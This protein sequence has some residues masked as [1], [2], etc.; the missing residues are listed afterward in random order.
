MPCTRKLSPSYSLRAL[1]GLSPFPLSS[2]SIFTKPKTFG[3]CAALLNLVVIGQEVQMLLKVTDSWTLA[4]SKVCTS[5]V[6]F[7]MCPAN[8]PG[9]FKCVCGGGAV[10]PVSGEMSTLRL[11]QRFQLEQ[12]D[13][14]FALKLHRCSSIC[15]LS[16]HRKWKL[17]APAVFAQ[18]R[19]PSRA[20]SDVCIKAGGSLRSARA[21][22]TTTP[23]PS[24][25]PSP[26][27]TIKADSLHVTPPPSP[28]HHRFLVLHNRLYGLRGHI[29]H[30]AGQES[31]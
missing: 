16:W 4:H 26:L 31:Q 25:L 6:L 12:S 8:K 3:T 17:F 13:C 21:L 2:P 15:P 24:I 30:T 1:A 7:G 19:G 18:R 5:L 27:L 28:P 20:C 9:F 14:P 23:S 29:C 22:V 10:F 11:L